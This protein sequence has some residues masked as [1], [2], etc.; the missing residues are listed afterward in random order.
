MSTDK[1]MMEYLNGISPSFCGAKWYNATIWLGSGMSTSCHHPPAHYVNVEDVLKNP[2]AIHNTPEKK[3]DRKKMQ[4]GSRPTGCEY[5]W[6]IEDM[7]RGAISDRAYKSQIYTN[8]ELEAAANL[9]PGEDVNLITLEIAFDRTC[10]FAC[11]YC[12]PAFSTTWV[13]DIK[14]QGP[15]KN[16]ISDGR[17]HYTHAHDSAQRYR[18]K[19]TNPY[20]EAFFKWWDTDLHKTLRELRITGGEPLMSPDTWRLMEWFEA[21]KGKSECV[22]AI[23]SNMV[24]KPVKKFIKQTHNMAPIELYTSCEAMG[25]QAEYIRDGLI[26]DEWLE[27]I[28][29][30]HNHGNIAN[31][32]IMCTINSLCL[33]TL[34]EFLTM[35]IRMK[36]HTL[37]RPRSPKE[38]NFSLNILRF[39]S[40]QS[41]L[42][43][44]KEMRMKHKAEL[45]TWLDTFWDN[46]SGSFVNEMEANQVQRLIDYLDVVKTPH[47]DTFDQPALENDFKEF[48]Q[49]YDER[50]GKDFC[51]TFPHLA[52]WYNTLGEKHE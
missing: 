19:E 43:L 29:Y 42:V 50:R 15:Y 44:P 37:G 13:K 39:P 52:E 25:K 41:P 23:N 47:S 11:S 14:R 9:N 7:D 3:N 1:E 34:P 31:F 48:Y 32:H 45:E 4:A 33:E 51:A 12:N 6:K 35:I 5:C 21:N 8:E 24:G 10:N 20:V 2:K 46:G 49:Q 17:N 30:A 40:F 18:R 22:L 27:N 38:I 16:L 26:W 28:R 36:L